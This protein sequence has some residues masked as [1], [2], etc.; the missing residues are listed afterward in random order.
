MTSSG[1]LGDSNVTNVETHDK[2]F[3]EAQL[4]CN[5]AYD[6]A[7]IDVIIQDATEEVINFIGEPVSDDI[8]SSNFVKSA[9]LEKTDEDKY[10]NLVVEA[11][12][13]PGYEDHYGSVYHYLAIFDKEGKLVFSD[14]DYDSLI[15]PKEIIKIE[16]DDIL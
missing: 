12:D 14:D 4:Q 8:I 16:K 7:K 2:A 15:E 5:Y 9:K 6:I 11:T 10:Y 13:F 3:A 1:Y